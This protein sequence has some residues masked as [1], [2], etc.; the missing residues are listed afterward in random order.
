M[1][2]SMYAPSMFQ[3]ASKVAVKIIRFIFMLALLFII[4]LYIYCCI[5]NSWDSIIFLL[6]FIFIVYALY[7]LLVGRPNSYIEVDGQNIKVVDYVLFIKRKRIIQ[8]SQIHE[9]YIEPVY[10]KGRSL[11][12]PE[13]RPYEIIFENEDYKKLFRVYYTEES[14]EFFRKYIVNYEAHIKRINNI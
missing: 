10:V 11:M 14:C 6:P 13:N 12:P 4:G 3:S 9:A 2:F 7:V 8:F 1:R 5:L